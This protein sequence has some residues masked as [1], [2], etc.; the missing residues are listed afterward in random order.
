MTDL[1][2]DEE[3]MT[4]DGIEV[5]SHSTISDDEEED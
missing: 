4:V 3:D 1:F 2:A 5:F